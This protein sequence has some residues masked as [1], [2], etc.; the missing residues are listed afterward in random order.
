MAATLPEPQAAAGAGDD[1]G[2]RG[3]SHRLCRIA[4]SA[5]APTHIL[6]ISVRSLILWL[7]IL[8]ATGIWLLGKRTLFLCLAGTGR[9]LDLCAADR[10]EPAGYPSA[11]YGQPFSLSPTCWGDKKAL[12]IVLRLRRGGG[13]GRDY[14]AN[15]SM[16]PHFND[17]F[18]HH[19]DGVRRLAVTIIG[20][21]RPIADKL[22]EEE[23]IVRRRTGFRIVLFVHAWRT[24]VTGPF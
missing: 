21:K 9:D 10:N 14:A 15:L 2:I 22:G 4:S 1:T 6:V 8:V 11:D 16:T 20:I 23:F 12:I 5:A 19:R 18:L 3:I 7:G 13:D 24:I 17:F